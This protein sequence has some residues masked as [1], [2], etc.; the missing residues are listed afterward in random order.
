MTDPRGKISPV[1]YTTLRNA[2]MSNREIA[3][4]LGINEASVRRGLKRARNTAGERR[5]MVTVTELD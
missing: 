1:V 4:Q 3:R 5:F 2:G